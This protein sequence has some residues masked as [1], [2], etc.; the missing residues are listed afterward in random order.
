M[1]WVLLD[2][3]C[4]GEC[5]F[6]LCTG[7]PHVLMLALVWGHREKAKR[8]TEVSC[9]SSAPSLPFQSLKQHQH[10]PWDSLLEKMKTSPCSLGFYYSQLNEIPY[11]W[12]RKLR[13]SAKWRETAFLLG[14]WNDVPGLGWGPDLCPE[15]VTLLPGLSVKAGRLCSES[16]Y[17]T[18]LCDVLDVCSA[19]DCRSSV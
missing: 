12:M 4:S 1:E 18:P 8:I 9:F 17:P 16:S 13:K 15:P 14:T 19:L 2:F 3:A 10:S 6:V 5:L 11:W 7:V